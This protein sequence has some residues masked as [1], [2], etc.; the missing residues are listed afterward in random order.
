MVALALSVIITG[1]SEI[2]QIP[3]SDR[4]KADLVDRVTPGI[5]SDSL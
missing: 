4:L 1:E 3:I 5:N 2:P